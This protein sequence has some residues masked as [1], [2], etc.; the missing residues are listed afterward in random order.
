MSEDLQ[1]LADKWGASKLDFIISVVNC[2]TTSCKDVSKNGN[3]QDLVNYLPLVIYSIY[4]YMSSVVV[5]RHSMTYQIF[6]EILYDLIKHKVYSTS[7]EDSIDH[8]NIDQNLAND[9]DT[10]CFDHFQTDLEKNLNEKSIGN[11]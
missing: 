6:G 5:K 4:E 8:F 3:T 2:Y 1:K 10:W 9:C 11:S 7:E